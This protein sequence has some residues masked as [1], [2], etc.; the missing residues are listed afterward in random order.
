MATGILLIN[1]KLH[2]NVSIKQALESTGR[3]Q[4]YPFTSADT[5]FDFLQANPGR[6]T[7]ALVDFTLKTIAGDDVVR[8]L[9][10]LQP[11]LQIIISP[12]QQTG[13]VIQDLDLQGM[14]PYPFSARDV[15]TLVNDL[16]SPSQ[17]VDLAS[18]SADKPDLEDTGAA[19]TVLDGILAGLGDD[20]IFE[21]SD[22]RA[23]TPIMPPFGSDPSSGS[24]LDFNIPAESVSSVEE[25]ARLASAIF[26]RLAQEEPPMPSLEESGTVSDLI[27]DSGVREVVRALQSGSTPEADESADS[28]AAGEPVNGEEGET[29]AAEDAPPVPEETSSTSGPIPAQLILAL[30]LDETTPLNPEQLVNNIRRQLLKDKAPVQPLPSWQREDSGESGITEPDFL[31]QAPTTP[32]TDL[33]EFT[34]EFADHPTTPSSAEGPEV[35][36]DP[37][38]METDWLTPESDTPVA[39]FTPADVQ[40]TDVGS[41][42]FEPAEPDAS[43]DEAAAIPEPEPEPL[44]VGFEGEDDTFESALF[45]TNFE[46]LAAFD[47][48]V[49][50]PFITQLALSLTQVS[51]ETAAE[52]TL[53][54]NP[55]GDVIASAGT[56]PDEDIAEILGV[57]GGDWQVEGEQARVRFISLPVSS[58]DYLL[59]SR[60][61]VNDLTLSMIFGGA[62]NLSEIRKQG[63]RLVNALQSIP[64]T[65]TPTVEE[66]ELSGESRA[67]A[68][69]PAPAPQPIDRNPYAVVW[70]LRDPTAQL[71]PEVAGAIQTGLRLQLHEQDWEVNTLRVDEDYVYMLAQVPEGLSP[72]KFIPDLKARAEVIALAQDD[73][74]VGALWAPS[75][76]VITPGRELEFEEIQQFISFDRAV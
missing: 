37:S 59:Y 27:A 19:G 11:D 58:A 24:V 6:I 17:Q 31:G 38:S 7:L 40:P 13:T 9:R 20:V 73:R 69:A 5:A 75:Y 62:T 50:D 51:L 54:T 74:L 29:V 41:Q 53:L 42:P 65:P 47:I 10:E 14:L 64:E 32:L 30:A 16:L 55:Q 72:Q 4:V 34:E 3:F 49:E 8:R 52:A 28:P 76:Y 1:R 18:A 36:S 43:T 2:F 63:K 26:Q 60:R 15:I 70:L 21:T 22:S 71:S 44:P 56:L 45:D 25:D 35:A 48:T 46:N 61:T 23:P 12:V 66:V 67:I 68:P 57:I 39:P 33:G